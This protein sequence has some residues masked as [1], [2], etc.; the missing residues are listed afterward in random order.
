LV[1]GGF[2]GIL[3]SWNAF[4]IGSSRLMF[5]MARGGMLP[6]VFARLHPRYDS[7][8][9]VIVLVTALTALAPFFGR[10]ALVWLVD[11]G[12]LAVV[13]GYFL[14]AVSYLRIRRRYPDLPR[15]YRVGAPMAV[16][17][18]A[19]LMTVFFILLYL[20]GSPSALVWPF[21][22]AIVLG[23]AALGGVFSFAVRKRT[24]A[25]GRET[26]ARL[27]LGPYAKAL[28]LPATRVTAEPEPP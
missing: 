26:Q 6:P 16:G 5:A 14:V 13:V 22:W 2:M 25:L 3:T 18:M 27:I 8:V 20:P 23:W 4:F 10:R 19:L 12:G 28:E 15:P 21:E 24:A 9:A 11:A 1:V 17:T 7:P